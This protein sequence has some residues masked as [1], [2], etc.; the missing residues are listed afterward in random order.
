MSSLYGEPDFAFGQ[1]ML[2]L[3]LATGLT[4]A[5]LAE[6]LGVSRHA[7]GEWEAGHSYPKPRH[8]KNFIALC[9]K[10]GAFGTSSELEEIR[11][12]WKA[13]NQKA[14]LDEKWLHQLLIERNSPNNVVPAPG[15]VILNQPAITGINTIAEESEQRL[16]WGEAIDVPTFYGRKTELDQLSQWIVEENCRVVSVLGMGGMGKSA[17][18]VSLMHRLATHFEVVIW[19]SVRD[20][21]DCETLLKGCLQIL[22][23]EVLN[24]VSV[25]FERCLSLLLKQ[26]QSRRVLLVL[27]N[28]E[29]LL[30]EGQNAGYLRG[31]YENYGRLLTLL[32]ETSHHSCLLL[33]SREKPID[34]VPLEGKRSVVRSLRLT[35]LDEQACE[36]LLVDKDVRGTPSQRAQ[37]SRFFTGNPLALKIVAQTIV[38]LFDGEIARFLEQGEGEAIFGGVRRLLDEQFARLSVMEQTVLMWLA[39][40]REPSSVEEVVAALVRPVSRVRLLE[41]MEALHHRSLIERG[42]KAGTFT[43]QSVVLEYLTTRL[44]EEVVEELEEGNLNRLVQHS[45]MQA[46]ARDYVRQSQGRLIIQPVLGRF[47]G[48]GAY[49]H[50]EVEKVEETLREVLEQVR[51]LPQGRQGYAGGNLIN[52]LLAGG[53]ELVGWDFSGLNLW[54]AYLAGVELRDV[55]F[56]GSDLSRS[57]FTEG[58]NSILALAY[59]PDG[60]YLAGGSLTGE[61]NIWQ[62]RQAAGVNDYSL[63]LECRGHSGVVNSVTYSPDG[64]LLASGGYDRTVRVWDAYSGQNLLVLSDHTDTVRKVV[65]SPD[66]TLVVSGSFDGTIKIWRIATGQLLTTLTGHSNWVWSVAFSPEGNLLAS[67]STDGTI[68]LWE[69][70][71]RDNNYRQIASLSAH[72]GGVQEVFFSPEGEKF[73]SCGSDGKILEWSVASQEMLWSLEGHIGMVQAL[74]VSPDGTI[75]ASGGNDLTVRLWQSGNHKPLLTLTGHTAPLVGL[76]FSPDG[77]ILASSS[78]DRSLRLWSVPGGQA[79]ITKQGHI[80]TVRSIAVNRDGTYLAGAGSNKNVLVWQMTGQ[81]LTSLHHFTPSTLLKGHTNNLLAVAFSPDGTTLASAGQDGVIKIWDVPRGKV[82]SPARLSLTSNSESISALTYNP[83]GDLL[84]SGSGSG[85]VR[86]WSVIT[87]EQMTIFEGHQGVVWTV[88]FSPDGTTIVSGGND[89]IVRLWDTVSGQ[90]KESLDK[91]RIPILNITYHP[92]GQLLACARYDGTI[93]VWSVTD[94]S[95]P[96]LTL[97]A[98]QAPVWSLAFNPDPTASSIL[99]SGGNDG[100][101]RLWN[102][103]TRE[104]VAHFAHEGFIRSVAFTK[105]GTG[106]ISAGEDG[107]VKQWDIRSRRLLA[108]YRDFHPY[109]GVNIKGATGLTELGRAT[110]LALGAIEI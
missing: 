5:N 63:Y 15:P 67:G 81:D 60:R 80:K 58:F 93:L 2:T 103:E 91:A 83:A 22:A 94:N 78:A 64:K 29:T 6:F 89:G 1:L 52:L 107:L 36:Q 57:I 100:I 14:L 49:G 50:G 4:Q 53:S 39:I 21:P 34:L 110:L 66:G 88:A 43:L 65:F 54:E 8:L 95:Q 48:P 51:Q 82:S 101:A 26:L 77:Q 90:L 18:T 13:S 11:A 99:L 68:R 28:L 73:F 41:I 32:G 56:A 72:Q 109:E 79:L 25:S 61:I 10:Q 44:V 96:L 70:N 76:A 105:D 97:K 42:G 106:I 3:R 16:D 47:K 55:N 35:P 9:L 30:E 27:D 59:S 102:I 98:N 92:E 84:A 12:L 24:E 20:A 108:I 75:L 7:V 23:P 69:I 46:Q 104:E 31:G 17:L 85:T 38:D 19:R 33:T 86:A 37:L 40:L 45:L 62:M 71:L 74:A 87:G